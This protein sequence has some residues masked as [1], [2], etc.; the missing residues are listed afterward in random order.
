MPVL[1]NFWV[2]AARHSSLPVRERGSP[3][4]YVLAR[5]RLAPGLQ[6]DPPVRRRCITYSNRSAS[7]GFTADA[8]FFASRDGAAIWE[9]RWTCGQ[10]RRPNTPTPFVVPT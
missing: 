10:C 4:P 9:P 8:R 6:S 7:V 5:V 3:A 2:P 1:N